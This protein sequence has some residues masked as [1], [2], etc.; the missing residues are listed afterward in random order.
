MHHTTLDP[1]RSHHEDLY[2]HT[3]GRAVAVPRRHRA[4]SRRFAV[5]RPAGTSRP[6]TVIAPGRSF[7]GRRAGGRRCAV[8]RPAGTARPKRLVA[9]GRSLSG[10]RAP[11]L[12]RGPQR[13]HDHADLPR[14]GVGA[15]RRRVHRHARDAAPT[16]GELSRDEGR[17]RPAAG[18]ALSPRAGAGR[19]TGRPC[20][21]TYSI[22]NL[23]P[24]SYSCTA[25]ANR[26][27]PA[28]QLLT[29]T[30]S[31]TTTADFSLARR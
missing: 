3:G 28:T 22:P 9:A 7:P 4:G 29:V 2:G 26:Y 13:V 12:G 8:S 18:G 27:A 1:R 19:M 10:R 16:S 30:S 14:W 23:A 31:Q 6:R 25:G 24:G 17:R 21:S 15:H 5:S 20:H 11:A